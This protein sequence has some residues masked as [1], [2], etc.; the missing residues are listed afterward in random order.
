MD[1]AVG[2]AADYAEQLRRLT[3]ND[4]RLDD[5]RGLP[6]AALPPRTL[7]LLRLAALVGVGGAGPSFG[8][9]VEA[10]VGAGASARDVVDVLTA[11]APVV[12]LPQVVAAAPWVALGLGLEPVEGWDDPPEAP[13]G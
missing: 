4:A 2:D 10:A 3:I 7:A 11:V 13:V 9:E 12:G 8:A 6:A 1:H 5:G